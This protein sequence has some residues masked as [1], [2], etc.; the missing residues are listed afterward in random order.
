MLA[1]EVAA[2]GVGEPPPEGE[3][4]GGAPDPWA[5]PPGDAEA[6]VPAQV[7]IS[8][9]GAE[10]A[11]AP[12]DLFAAGM[13]RGEGAGAGAGFCDGGVLDALEPGAVLAGFAADTG[14]GGLGRISD[15]ELIGVVRAWRR[16]SSWAA[17]GELAAVGELV[18]RRERGRAGRG[19]GGVPAFDWVADELAC[20]LTLTR[21]SAENLAGRAL[22][23]ADL[24]ATAAALALGSIDMPKALAIMDGVAGLE[25]GLARAVE[26][27]VLVKAPGE[28]AGELRAAVRR[29]V[30]A[31]DPAAARVRRETAEKDARVEL[32]DEPAGTKALAGRDLPPAGVLAADQRISAIARELKTRGAAGG[33]DVLRA[34]VY[35]ALLAGQPLDQLLDQLLPAP[36]GTD[37]PPGD[38]PPAHGTTTG[39]AA[40]AGDRGPGDGA[41]E[42]GPAGDRRPGDGAGEPA[43]CPAWWRR[44][45]RLAGRARYQRHVPSGQGR[46]G[47]RRGR[48][49]GRPAGAGRSAPGP[50]PVPG[51]TPAWP[52][53]STWSGLDLGRLAGS[54]NLTV[55]LTTLLDLADE[56]G[57]AAGFGPLDA[58]TTRLLA[59]AAARHPATQW[60]LTVTDG[61]GRVIGHGCRGRD[62][63]SPA[64]DRA[65]P[66][67]G[68]RASPGGAGRG[69]VIKIDP[70]A[71]PG[72]GHQRETRGYQLTPRLRHL[73]EIRD[74][75][76]TFP[77][78]RRPAVRCDK[79]HTVPYGH[80]GR[81]CECN[82]AALCRTHHQ[83]KQADGWHLEQPAPG[84][85]QWT[86][87]SGRTYTTGLP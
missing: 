70:L 53:G 42:T 30:L 52:A 5:D 15:D 3:L 14:A 4:W 47:D 80:G 75:T 66:G 61:T 43:G 77:G 6:D 24:P 39:T 31:A 51:I 25:R 62:R 10:D 45:G 13:W 59:G 21:W 58:A 78:C 83:V 38:L 73:I 18:A 26:D 27:M 65:S 64:G 69:L 74:R 33:L 40:G 72:C 35:L 49:P 8:G 81:T 19:G 56:P 67:G 71:F 17:A 55:P 1:E 50:A 12:P 23:L 48:G 76:C 29:A 87:P 79:D 85:L 16:L 54:V 46:W 32:W 7:W 63:A 20:A 84:V 34:R 2:F 60:C 41:G 9:A 82:T 86:T 22:R 44:G 37:Q 57:E 11:A 68:D 36:A 28:T